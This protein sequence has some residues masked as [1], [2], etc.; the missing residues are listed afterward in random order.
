MDDALTT[1]AA[2]R[3]RVVL[4]HGAASGPWVFDGWAGA[5]PDDDVRV[6]DLQEGLDVARASMSDYADRVLAAAGAGPAVLVGWSMG[7]LVAMMAARRRRPLA[8]VVLEPSVPAEVDGGDPAWP[9]QTGTYDAAAVYGPPRPGA[10]RRPESLLAR[11]ERKRGISV[12]AVDCPFLVVAGRD[13]GATRGRPVAER[14]GAELAEFPEVSHGGLVS[15]PRV[16][17]AVVRWVGSHRE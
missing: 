10:R 13:Y 4:V 5:F 11:S 17:D 9:I 12:P 7:G 6:P 8:L 16:R 14:Y 1:D 3:R 2:A 15:D